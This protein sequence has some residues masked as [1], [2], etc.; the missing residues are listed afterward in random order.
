VERNKFDQQL[1]LNT[2]ALFTVKNKK[3]KKKEEREEKEKK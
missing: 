3:N 2:S 1:E